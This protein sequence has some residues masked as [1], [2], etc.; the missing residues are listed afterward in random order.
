MFLS[1]YKKNINKFLNNNNKLVINSV[2]TWLNYF[3]SIANR[4]RPLACALKNINKKKLNFKIKNIAFLAHR[5]LKCNYK[6]LKCVMRFFLK[7]NLYYILYSKMHFNFNATLQVKHNS[8]IFNV[9]QS[10][11]I[12][13]DFFQFT[14]SAPQFKSFQTHK[15]TKFISNNLFNLAQSA[16]YF[17]WEEFTIFMFSDRT[18]TRFYFTKLNQY[19]YKFLV[20][21]MILFK[22]NQIVSSNSLAIWNYKKSKLAT[23]NRLSLSSLSKNNNVSMLRNALTTVSFNKLE[24]FSFFFYNPIFFKFLIFNVNRDDRYN[25]TNLIFSKSYNFILQKTANITKNVKLLLNNLFH[26]EHFEYNFNKILFKV[27]DHS[28]FGNDNILWH[29]Q[30][31]IRFLEYCSGRKVYFRIHPFIQNSLTFTEKMQCLAWSQKVKYFRRILGPR[32]FLNESLQIIYLSLKLH[33]PYL[34]SNWMASILKK[35][36]F[37]KSKTFLRYIKYVLKHFFWANFKKIP[38]NGVKFQ[39]KGKISVAGNS[40]TRTAF[41]TVGST[42]HSCFNNKI[43]FNLNLFRTFTGVQGLKLWIVF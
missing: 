18:K 36:S 22:G 5:V 2:Q 28:K 34:L 1:L 19:F 14:E 30:L 13:I 8:N 3:D 40:R 33:D 24:L 16:I 23:T 38:V 32:L 12:I 27:F 37:W 39:L 15:L 42:S 20:N 31:L 4:A 43:L 10:E 26:N 41:H 17:N 21:N 6:L 35:I 11:Q 7:N 29:Y 25:F 9:L